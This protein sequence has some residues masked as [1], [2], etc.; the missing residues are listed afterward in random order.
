MPPSLSP[1]A[2]EKAADSILHSRFDT[3]ELSKGH[4]LRTLE[5]LS[6]DP[7]E[8]A[9]LSTSFTYDN[10][11]EKARNLS[12]LMDERAFR[13]DSQIG[14]GFIKDRDRMAQHFGEIGRQIDQAFS[15]GEISKQE[16]DDLNAGLARYTETVTSREERGNAVA[17]ALRKQSKALRALINRG[18]SQVEIEAFAQQCRDA[19]ADEVNKFITGSCKIDRNLMSQLIQRVRGGKDL[20]QRKA[21][22]FGGFHI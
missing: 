7:H 9:V 14:Y 8:G 2:M 16:Y 19:F 6:Y 20:V 13:V 12:F 5:E 21:P 4:G 11:S 15:A 22:Q 17:M 1:E 18:A 3:V 10:V